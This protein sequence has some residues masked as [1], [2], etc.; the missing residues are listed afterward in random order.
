MEKKVYYL[1]LISDTVE[2]EHLRIINNKS[3]TE[4]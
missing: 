3:L 2:L 1:P 4:A